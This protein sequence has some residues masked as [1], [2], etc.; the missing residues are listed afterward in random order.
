M[1]LITILLT[2]IFLILISTTAIFA[3]TTTVLTSTTPENLS[4][5]A[6]GVNVNGVNKLNLL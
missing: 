5:K 6:L 4:Y 1:E 2:T 3:S